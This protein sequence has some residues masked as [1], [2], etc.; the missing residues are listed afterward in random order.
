M[1]TTAFNFISSKKSFERINSYCAGNVQEM[2]Q[3]CNTVFENAT[4]SFVDKRRAYDCLLYSTLALDAAQDTQDLCLELLARLGCT[5]PKRMRTFH[6]LS[7]CLRINSSVDKTIENVSSLKK[8]G[9]VEDKWVVCL[10]DTL[11]ICAYHSDDN[12]LLPLVL[13]ESLRSTL[14]YG[15]SDKSPVVLVAVGLLLVSLGNLKGAKAYSDKAMELLNEH[16]G[17]ATRTVFLA[18]QFVIHWQVPFERCLKPLLDTVH[19]GLKLGDL[20]S[21]AWSAYCYVDMAL[22]GGRNLQS[23]MEDCKELG[24]RVAEMKQLKILNHIKLVWQLALCLNQPDTA[25][26]L[27]LSN[28]KI[29]THNELRRWIDENN[30]ENLRQQMTRNRMHAK[31]WLGDYEGMA[32]M[33]KENKTDK[34]SAEEFHPGAFVIPPFY[35]QCAICCFTLFRRTRQKS[36]KKSGMWFAKKINAWAKKGVSNS[37]LDLDLDIYRFL[38]TSYLPRLSLF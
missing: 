6:L 11:S 36:L 22:H 16:P 12:T 18:N 38:P 15:L 31:F 30:D 27:F 8:I 19:V 26:D 3:D 10:L 1:S 2:K 37:R 33:I 25:N 20:D 21:A 9:K 4:R 32:K 34:G 13:I 28:G 24:A 5:F 14:R 35:L 17:C 7:G 23:I 29:V